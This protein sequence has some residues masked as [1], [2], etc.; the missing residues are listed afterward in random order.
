MHLRSVAEL[1]AKVG[2]LHKELETQKVEY[3]L[4]EERVKQSIAVEST[5]KVE[6]E[7]RPVTSLCT[8]VR[9]QMHGVQ[10]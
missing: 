7:I 2:R 1:E 6:Q 4:I 10:L 3:E 8:R 5:R 9:L